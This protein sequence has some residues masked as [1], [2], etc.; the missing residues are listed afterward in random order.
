MCLSSHNEATTL[1]ELYDSSSCHHIRFPDTKAGRQ[2]AHWLVSW[3]EHS[4]T[5]Y[6]ANVKTSLYVLRLGD[7]LL[8]VTVNSQEY[9]NSYVCSPYTHYVTYAKQ[10]LYKL[11]LPWLESFLSRL[12]DGI[13]VLLKASRMNQVVHVNNSLLSTNLYPAQASSLLPEGLRLLRAQ[14]PEHT[15][16]FRSLV[17]SMNEPWIEALRREKFRLV[18]SRQVYLFEPPNAKA[19]WLIKRDRQLIDK[20]GYEVVCSDQLIFSDIPRLKSLYDMLYLDKHSRCNPWFTEDFFLQALELGTL[21]LYA[22]RNAS[23]RSLDAVLGYYVKD[24][25]MTTPVFGYDTS[26]PQE[27]G[28]Y[29][30]LSA[31]LIGISEQNGW[32]LHESS[33][34]AEFKRNRGAVGD[35]EYSAVLDAH[36]PWQRRISWM[37]LERLLNR[38]GVPLMR[39]WKL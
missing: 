29:R 14:F 17:P 21:Q 1:V 18:P 9:E 10:E 27:L 16:I 32:K 22:L 26:L 7:D 23:S 4:P 25:V 35:I 33:G 20:H 24:G 36:L 2:A 12:L 3:M 11:K 28:L 37:V 5:R 31:V 15:I 13:G 38:I 39:K 34:A 8:P 30:M 19:R 6:I